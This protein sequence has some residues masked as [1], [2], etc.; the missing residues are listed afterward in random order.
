PGIAALCDFIGQAGGRASP[1][2][3]KADAITRDLAEALGAQNNRSVTVAPEAG[4]ERMRRVINKNLTEPEI[5][6][7]AEWLVGSGVQ[8]LKL[9]FMVGAPTETREDVEAIADLTS[10][11]H[12]R[13]C[14]KSAK[15][16]GLTLSVN[17]FS[18]KPWTPFQWEPM[19]E[20]PA[21]REKL[22]S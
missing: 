16:G 22:S 21:L 5:L 18:P 4:S 2:S 12:Q 13:F 15:V 20:I 9:Y 3:L 1:S 7:A 10:K 8:S 6:R 11:I 17:A 19:E 14:G